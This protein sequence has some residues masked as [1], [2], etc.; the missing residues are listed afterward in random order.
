MNQTKGYTG[1]KSAAAAIVVLFL[2]IVGAFAIR[3]HFTNQ[4]VFDTAYRFDRAIVAL[5]TGEV[6]SGK[7][8]SWKDYPDGGMVQ[9]RIGGKTYYTHG[10]NV[11]L[12]QDQD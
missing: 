6:A 7:V 10:S 4:T 11:V 5:P 1:I 12:I 9:V 8:D 3:S 2:L